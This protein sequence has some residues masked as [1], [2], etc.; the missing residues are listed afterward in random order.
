[1]F[2]RLFLV[3]VTLFLVFFGSGLTVLAYDTDDS[4]NNIV[5]GYDY[6]IKPGTREWVEAGNAY[7][8]VQACQIPIEILDKL[9]TEELIESV[10][11]Y[12][13]LMDIYAFDSLQAGFESVAE[14][15]NGLE[16]L[17]KRD[18][19]V[20]KILSKYK[21]LEVDESLDKK[22]EESI[23]ILASL[24]VI[25]GQDE[26]IEQ[27]DENQKMELEKELESKYLLKK[28]NSDVYGFTTSIAY[29]IK[30]EARNV[31]V[32]PLATYYVY[33]PRGTA[34]AVS[35]RGELLTPAEKVAMDNYVRNTYPGIT[36]V[37]TATT[38]YNCHSYAWYNT[39]SSNLYWMNSAYAYMSDGSYIRRSGGITGNRINDKIY[40]GATNYLHSGIVYA[41]SMGGNA[42]V[43][44]K[45][46]S[47]GLVK[48]YYSNCPYYS[49]S[50][51]PISF[52]YR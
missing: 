17:M 52:W 10:I 18:D 1:M 13:F 48:H 9:S 24:E 31:L 11:N 8:R 6:P 15:F 14:R 50:S 42:Y 47:M 43:Q 28:S 12:P 36:V 21:N 37:R 29:R 3:F 25:L 34:V 32:S 19:A 46:G 4:E 44:S 39:S 20:Y 5:S 38:N 45:W 7:E 49:G 26:L 40:Y 27:L 23:F 41:R 16:E 30:S 33:T 51:T 22:S 2:K 35:R